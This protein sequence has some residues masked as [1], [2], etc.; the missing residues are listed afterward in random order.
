M[1]NL[2]DELYNE[3]FNGG[4]KYERNEKIKKII[5]ALQNYNA[6]EPEKMRQMTNEELGEPDSIEQRTQGGY[7]YTKYVWRNAKGVFVRII[8]TD[9]RNKPV[10]LSLEEQLEVA[11]EAEDWDLAIE[12]MEKINFKKTS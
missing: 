6:I 11:K 1:G 9:E 3:F 10:V 5:Q 4:E 7:I 2:F 8:I 12:I